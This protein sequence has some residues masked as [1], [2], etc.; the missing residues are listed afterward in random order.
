MKQRVKYE[1]NSY[2]NEYYG[3]TSFAKTY[4][5][6]VLKYNAEVECAKHLN[7][8]FKEKEWYELTAEDLQDTVYMP[9]YMFISIKNLETHKIVKHISVKID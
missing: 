7:D 1:I 5:D 6:A 9:D 2:G 4:K 3:S 8:S